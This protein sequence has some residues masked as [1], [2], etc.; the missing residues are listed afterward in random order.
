VEAWSHS[1]RGGGEKA[2]LLELF[3][4]NNDE[5][6]MSTSQI[7][8]IKPRAQDP[9]TKRRTHF[10]CWVGRRTHEKRIRDR[11]KNTSTSRSTRED[12]ETYYNRLGNGNQERNLAESR[13]LYKNSKYYL[14][15][16]Q[17]RQN[18]TGNR[19]KIERNPCRSRITI[20][21]DVSV[22]WRVCNGSP[23]P[24]SPRPRAEPLFTATH[25]PAPTHLIHR[26]S[27]RRR[28]T[29]TQVTCT[30]NNIARI[31]PRQNP[32]NEGNVPG[33]R[34]RARSSSIR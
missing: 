11:S 1:T 28:Q 31:H 16:H 19:K 2:A 17:F 5:T 27:C 32:T 10:C 18:I 12:Q 34:T 6:G 29:P 14:L 15:H 21:A 9:R 13:R 3:K 25:Y 7:Q 22:L 24:P 23:P 4:D 20:L 26:P 33:N 30:T 8:V